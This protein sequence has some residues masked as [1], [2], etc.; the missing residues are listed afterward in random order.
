MAKLFV[1][2]DVDWA[3]DDKIL[4]AGPLAGYLFLASIAFAKRTLSDGLIKRGQLLAIAPGLPNVPKHAAKLVE[5]GLWALHDAGWMIPS[6]F[7]TNQSRAHVE[8]AAELASENGTKGNHIK[9]HVNEGK[10]SPRCKFCVEDRLTEKSGTSR[11]PDRPP[12]AHPI[13]KTEPEGSKSQREVEPE[14]EGSKSQ[15]KTSSSSSDETQLPQNSTEIDDDDDPLTLMALGLLATKWTKQNAT[16][17]KER[18]YRI[19]IIR[20]A[21]DHLPLL[22]DLVN[23]RPRATAES[24]AAAY[25]AAGW[26]AVVKAEE[27]IPHPASCVCDGTGMVP[28]EVDAADHSSYVRPCT[29]PQNLATI[30][31]LRPA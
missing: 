7:K 14:T 25:E 29:A 5:V 13:A 19:A 26:A 3:S 2:L 1:P 17:G 11:L 28:V 15:A 10:T 22:R 24:V 8:A 20:N 6:W 16:K 9:H 18:G 12:E 31:Q 21:E 23:E 4:E 27:R 30:H